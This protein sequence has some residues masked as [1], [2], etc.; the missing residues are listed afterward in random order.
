MHELALSEAIAESVS[1]RA[2]S[3]P[4]T[5]ARVRV[6]H[7]R[8]VV[9]DALTFAWSMVTDG[10]AL[11]GCNL[12]VE[13]VPAVVACRACDAHTELS[14]PLLVCAACGTTDVEVLTGDELL[15]V[16]IEIAAGQSRR[17]R[18]ML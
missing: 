1:A 12:V 13:H 18:R 9:P 2:G 16:S 15:L 14:V 10:T 11:D 5:E 17:A 3:R 7:L 4:V 8:Q 6:G